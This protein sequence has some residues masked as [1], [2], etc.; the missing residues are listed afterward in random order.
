MENEVV[1]KR[2]AFIDIAKCLLIILVV[3]GHSGFWG[4]KYFY[5]FHMPAFFMISGYL[6]KPAK[7]KND[8]SIWARYT[9]KRFT[10][11]YLMFYLFNIVLLYLLNRSNVLT[12][13]KNI[14]LGL[15]GG[16]SI[17]GV[18][19]FITCLLL[20]EVA[21]KYFVL[22]LNKR[23]VIILI[24]FFYIIGHIES[25]LLLSTGD[26]TPLIHLGFPWNIDVCFISIPYLAIGYYMKDY[27]DIVINKFS[28]KHI[29][30]YL[31]VASTGFIFLKYIGYTLDM[32]YSHY[33]HL[34][35]DIIVPILF[36][37]LI[38]IISNAID[39]YSISKY[40]S[41]IGENAMVIMYLHIPLNQLFSHWFKYNFIMYF[42][43]GTVVPI[44]FI[45]FI[46]KWRITKFL[47]LGYVD[48]VKKITT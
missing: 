34:I 30:L 1:F 16:R 24:L 21:L 25:V 10:I 18:F 22:K 26:E 5:W 13:A 19:W 2:K 15:Y 8:Y 33:T 12:L 44:I 47:F 23:T 3:L 6:M 45:Y 28:I 11:P 31:T 37:L 17:S 9:F 41:Y 27:I 14:I 4:S 43:I 35:L 32:K 7:N 29:V 42:L 39:K 20:S 46:R 48:S 36:T 38:M 40:I